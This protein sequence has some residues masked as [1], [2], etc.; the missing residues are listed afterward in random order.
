MKKRIFSGII[1][2]MLIVSVFAFTGCGDEYADLSP[3]ELFA[4][5]IKNL[6]N[7]SASNGGVGSYGE[8]TNKLQSTDSVTE[9]NLTIEELNVQGQNLTELGQIKAD[10]TA[11]SDN[12]NQNASIKGS[13]S[14]FGETAPIEMTVADGNAYIVDLF[15]INEKALRI[16]MQQNGLDLD[17]ILSDNDLA[18]IENYSKLINELRDEIANAVTT[19]IEAN[20]NES[21]YSVVEVDTVVEGE[22][23]SDARIVTLT[24]T[25]KTVA[26]IVNS[27]IEEITKNEEIKKLLGNESIDKITEENLGG[28][29]S[30]VIENTVVDGKSVSINIKLN[31]EDKVYSVKSSFVGK[32]FTVK[33][34]IPEGSL[35]VKNSYDEETNKLKFTVGLNTEG[36]QYEI[37]N[38]TGT[39]IDGKFDGTVLLNLGT[40]SV[41]LNVKC[42]SGENSGKFS[43]SDIKIKDIAHGTE[44]TIPLTL[45][46]VYTVED[47]KA[48]FGGSIALNLEGMANVKMSFNSSV[49]CKDVTVSPVTD[50]VDANTISDE[51]LMTALQAKYPRIFSLLGEMFGASG[52]GDIDEF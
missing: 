46:L 32:N 21:A 22:E 40:T 29:K 13:F 43:L 10:F 45:S 31:A 30:L 18:S 27:F 50:Y 24:I 3:K 48:T 42:E 41:T 8:L 47:N 25:D 5:S 39:D 12:D 36:I 44:Q 28:F 23:F 33:V 9:M 26:S 11:Y 35:T 37:I 14:A 20:L 49:E 51:E 34:E 2:L 1:A 19:A 4:V 7:D 17:D 38:V 15:G 6:F 52:E 16:P